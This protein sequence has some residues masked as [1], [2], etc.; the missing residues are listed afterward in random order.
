MDALTYRRSEV[1]YYQHLLNMHPRADSRL[2][3]LYAHGQ[4]TL[5]APEVARELMAVDFIY[6]HTLYGEVIETFM[7]TVADYLR[8]MYGLT[9]TAT[10]RIA[11]FYA[12]IALKLMSLSATGTR[13]PER[14][15][16]AVPNSESHEGDGPPDAAG[17]GDV[18]P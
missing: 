7:R 15:P 18:Q 16:D 14:L 3:E 8:E 17:T 1:H 11:Q 10:W 9:W 13:I 5:S 6:K 4:T 12:P 2:T